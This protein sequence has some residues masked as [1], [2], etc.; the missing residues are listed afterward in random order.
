MLT[1]P[2][3]SMSG[4][5]FLYQRQ[6]IGL[7]RS[8]ISRIRELINGKTTYD[9]NR[10][11][12][13]WKT[14]GECALTYSSRPGSR[15]VWGNERDALSDLFSKLGIKPEQNDS[16]SG[17]QRM[18]VLANSRKHNGSCLAGK[19]LENG[20]WMRPTSNSLAGEVAHIDTLYADGTQ[21]QPLDIVQFDPG[22]MR[23]HP[24]Q[25][26]NVL[27]E[28]FHWEEVGRVSFE[29]LEDFRDHHLGFLEGEETRR[30]DRVTEPQAQEFGESLGLIYTIN[31]KLVVVQKG[32]R[33]Q[34]RIL[35]THEGSSFNLAVTDRQAEREYLNRAG[36]E[37]LL[38]RAYI[39]VSLGEPFHGYCYRLVACIITP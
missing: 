6:A 14:I 30:N 5:Q 24:H 1:P 36:T 4:S 7:E 13:R 20:Q 22:E 33:Q 38:P 35:F 28:H 11:Q 32:Y 16:A 31:A 18:V 19:V 10:A 8:L 34:L 9:E 27:F 2:I 23:A 21:I 26:E 15:R 3:S 39:C 12:V 29:E 25:R 17:R 37:H